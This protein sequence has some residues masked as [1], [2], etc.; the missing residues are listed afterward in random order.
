MQQAA[1]QAMQNERLV[2]GES[3][4]KFEEEFA[5]YCGT[6]HAI[7]TASGTAAL[8]LALISLGVTKE[9]V[10]TPMSFIATANSVIH[11]EA[12]P[13][14]VDV[15]PETYCINPAEIETTINSKTAAII[16]V[17]LYGY[18]ADMNGLNDVAKKHGLQIIEDACQAHGAKYHGARAGSFG[19][20]A[21]FSFYPP[22][23]MTVGG[24]GGMITTNDDSVNEKTRSLRDCG[25]A[26]G[27][28]Y[29]HK[30]VGFTERMNSIQAAIG[31]VQLRRLDSWNDR[32][33]EIARSYNKHLGG[34][35]DLVL[36]PRETDD[37]TPVYHLYVVR[38]KHRNEL[39]DWLEKRGV[40]C[41]IH[42]PVPIHLQ[43][44]YQ[45]LYGYQEGAFPL[46]EKFSEQV[47]SIPMYPGLA[48]A[49]VQLV[50]GTI[51][52][53]YEHFDENE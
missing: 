20:A 43:P 40:E 7:S 35:G 3:V 1:I 4:Y 27:E 52:E 16:P 50:A 44:A 11:A 21:A 36:P 22:K 5:G 13:R 51:R 6:D 14:F 37:I 34:I 17:H 42:Y 30:L 33:R 9:V 19:T 45:E 2:L 15:N 47:L 48:D 39:K 24:D 32:R 53:F 23:N 25:R 18:P 26:K 46:T 12:T 38:S 41:G 31:R 8:T 29:V 49:D 10:T 28:K